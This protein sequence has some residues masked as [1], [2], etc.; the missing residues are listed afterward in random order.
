MPS[1]SGAVLRPGKMRGTRCWNRLGLYFAAENKIVLN[2]AADGK[3]LT[4]DYFKLPSFIKGVRA[5]V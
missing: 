1:L 5:V 2:I 4:A 3:F